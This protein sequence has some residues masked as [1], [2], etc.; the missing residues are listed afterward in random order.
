MFNKINIQFYRG[1]DD[2]TFHTNIL[3][4]QVSGLVRRLLFLVGH[5]ISETATLCP[6]HW[7]GTS[8]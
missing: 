2:G 7:T 4:Y 5:N 8:G 1:P 3:Y 6:Q